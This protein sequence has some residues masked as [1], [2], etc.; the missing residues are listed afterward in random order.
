MK[1]FKK[2]YRDL[3]Q[4]VLRCLKDKI[5][6]SNTISS[7]TNQKCLK[8]NIFDYTELAIINDHLTFLDEN[9]L[10]YSIFNGDA[11]LEDLID[12]LNQTDNIK[13]WYQ[14]QFENDNLGD[15][16]NPN[17]TF[18]ELSDNIQ[19]VYEYLDVADSLVRERVFQELANRSNVDYSEIYEKWI[20]Y[21]F[22][23]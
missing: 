13:I 11:N 12:I 4:Q 17:A 2:E 21:N 15:E 23:L 10:H 8:V 22:S 20:N 5:N 3:E 14:S 16:I 1:N 7:H 18:K 6:N 19:Y 9:G